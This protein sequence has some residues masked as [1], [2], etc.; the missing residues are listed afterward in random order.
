MD[1]RRLTC[2]ATVAETLHF[3]RAAESLGMSQSAVSTH[4]RRLEEEVGADL[5][6]R[7][8]RRVALTPAGTELRERLAVAL[9]AL[10]QALTG[11]DDVAAGRGGRLRLGYVSS[12]SYA[13]L[14]A[15]V[16]TLRHERPGIEL[17]LEPLTTAEQLERIQEGTLDVGI[18]RD[19]DPGAP[20]HPR[21][22]LTEPLV[23]CLPSSHSLAGREAIEPVDLLDDA[24]IGY[25]RHLMPGYVDLVHAVFG[26]HAGRV[27][28]AH[29]V[30]HQETALGFIAA[31]EGVGILPAGVRDQL[32]AAVRALPLLT[33]LRS[34]ICAVTSRHPSVSPAAAALV[35][36]LADAA[37]DVAAA[38]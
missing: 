12:A 30:V 14:P 6:V 1:L 32:P 2:F 22:V 21:T 9:P 8:T 24:L 10:E 11:L 23:A 3:G 27:R 19:P 33:P 35:A 20:F 18:V 28:H 37:V 7:S 36:A 25:P 15:A 16:R 38:P 31:G 17:V 26:A 4:V 13:L 29:R 5:L 34:R